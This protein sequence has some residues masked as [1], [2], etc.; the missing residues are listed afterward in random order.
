M[1]CG[2]STPIWVNTLIIRSI[3]HRNHSGMM[4]AVRGMEDFIADDIDT[5]S[6]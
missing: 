5:A 3:Q 4:V 2:L 6:Y 1:Q